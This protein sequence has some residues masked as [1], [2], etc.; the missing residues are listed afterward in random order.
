MEESHEPAIRRLAFDAEMT[1]RLTA[2]LAR[3]ARCGSTPY[4]RALAFYVW[5]RFG[6]PLD[7]HVGPCDW[8]AAARNLL[9]EALLRGCSR[10]DPDDATCDR[11]P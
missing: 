1:R 8:S 11:F 6:P 5:K 3:A 4:R 10:E 2:G 9:R 7:P